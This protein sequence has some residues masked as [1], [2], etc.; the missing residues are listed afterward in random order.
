[1][2]AATVVRS[3]TPSLVSVL[4]SSFVMFVLSSVNRLNQ[5]RER[6]VTDDRTLRWADRYF[7]KDAASPITRATVS[8]SAAIERCPELT[9]VRRESARSAI[10]V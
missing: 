6:A 4:V 10:H 5:R 7:E 8:G 3:S 2:S 9:T 1:M